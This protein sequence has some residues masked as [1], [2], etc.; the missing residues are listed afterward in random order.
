MCHP[1]Q[2]LVEI[3]VSQTLLTRLA[4]N[5]NHPDITL[6]SSYDY[7]CETPAKCPWFPSML[8]GPRSGERDQ[9]EQRKLPEVPESILISI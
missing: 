1:T 9:L 2:L 4:W 6:P 3:R 7:R 5:C 8:Y